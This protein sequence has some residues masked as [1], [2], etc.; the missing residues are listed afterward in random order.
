MYVYIYIYVC[1]CG[2]VCVYIYRVG[3]NP[4]VAHV[5]IVNIYDIL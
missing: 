3:W 4:P 1:V 2:C 5:Y